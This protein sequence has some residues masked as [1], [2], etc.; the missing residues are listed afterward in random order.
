MLPPDE[1]LRWCKEN[2]CNYPQSLRFPLLAPDRLVLS[3]EMCAYYVKQRKW[4]ES[5]DSFQCKFYDFKVGDCTIL[6]LAGID[7]NN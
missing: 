2:G 4:F 5:M 1:V 6:V 7:F 3:G